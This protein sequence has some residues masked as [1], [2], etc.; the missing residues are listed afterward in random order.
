[1]LAHVDLQK[2]LGAFTCNE[3]AFLEGT[4]LLLTFALKEDATFE[5]TNVSF[6]L[7]LKDKAGT[8]A[9][10]LEGE[11]VIK[12]QKGKPL[13]LDGSG[14]VT[15]GDVTL[16]LVYL[17]GKDVPFAAYATPDANGDG[18]V[19]ISDVTMLLNVL[20]TTSG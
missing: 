18:Q 16:L 6:V 3:E 13:D 5:S 10:D 7:T 17:S 4:I 2:G 1:M 19:T 12:M 20:A 9:P 11:A 8:P 14:M 15:I